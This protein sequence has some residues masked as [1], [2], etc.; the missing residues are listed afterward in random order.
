M[1]SYLLDSISRMKSGGAY[2]GN[3]SVL[4][5]ADL[6]LE[7]VT[8][9]EEDHVVAALFNKFVNLFRLQVH[10]AANDTVLVHLQLVGSTKATISSRAFTDRRG[11]LPRHPRTT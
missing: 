6:R 10:A 11:S 3:D 1:W 2:V 7:R 4:E 8:A 5:L 9:V